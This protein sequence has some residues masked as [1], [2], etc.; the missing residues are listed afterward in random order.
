MKT[1]MNLLLWTDHVTEAQDEILDQ[2]KILGFDAVEIP[3]FNTTDLTAYPPTFREALAAQAACD[4]VLDS[5]EQQKWE[6]VVPV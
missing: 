4:A 5:A 3:T 6:T 2:I 1:G